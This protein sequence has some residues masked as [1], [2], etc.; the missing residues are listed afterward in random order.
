MTGTGNLTIGIYDNE[1]SIMKYW[2]ITHIKG[3]IFVENNIQLIRF[4]MPNLLTINCIGQT[5]CLVFRNN[6]QLKSIW[7]PQLKSINYGVVT[8]NSNVSVKMN[9]VKDEM[10]A[11]LVVSGGHLEIEDPVWMVE[12]VQLVKQGPPY[13]YSDTVFNVLCF[14]LILFVVLHLIISIYFFMENRKLQKLEGKILHEMRN[15]QEIIIK[16]KLNRYKIEEYQKKNPNVS[17]TE[18]V[19]AI[20]MHKPEITQKAYIRPSRVALHKALGRTGSGVAHGCRSQGHTIKCFA[21]NKAFGIVVGSR[22]DRNPVED[23]SKPCRSVTFHN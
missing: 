16:A 22:L 15:V 3:G 13:L 20:N 4:T 11:L 12:D 14:A 10:E 18:A 2:N 6:S 23:E 7:L 21:D 9:S 17:F 5:P 1:T 8:G 19:A